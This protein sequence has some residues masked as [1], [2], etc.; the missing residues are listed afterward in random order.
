MISLLSFA[1]KAT[2]NLTYSPISPEGGLA[3]FTILALRT[4]TYIQY[5]VYMHYIYIY[6]LTCF[7]LAHPQRLIW[8]EY[9]TVAILS[10]QN[11]EVKW[12]PISKQKWP[13]H[14]VSPFFQKGKV[15]KGWNGEVRWSIKFLD[16]LFFG[17]MFCLSV[18]G[19]SWL[20]YCGHSL[21]ACVFLSPI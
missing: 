7:F 16:L 19:I 5:Y 11:P 1:N 9:D 2:T 18:W 6:T 14:L 20:P 4:H 8:L 10:A 15:W 17:S 12:P 21:V 3:Y 13:M